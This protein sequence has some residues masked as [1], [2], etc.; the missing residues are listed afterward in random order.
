MAVLALSFAQRL[1]SEATAVLDF[2]FSPLTDA[3]GARSLVC[4]ELRR[5]SVSTA[6]L[7]LVERDKSLTLFHDMSTF[8]CASLAITTYE[9]VFR[10]VLRR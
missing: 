4:G 2:G 5:Q 8:A 3:G 1:L 7:D 6:L 10:Y 9:Q